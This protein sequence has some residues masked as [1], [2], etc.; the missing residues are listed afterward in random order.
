MP[1]V[2]RREAKCAA[3]GDRR[4]VAVVVP[5]GGGDY[6]LSCARLIIRDSWDRKEQDLLI[7]RWMKGMERQ[8]PPGWWVG[9]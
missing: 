3:C 4:S 9:A 8:V 1:R 2:S 5:D 7:L 6:C